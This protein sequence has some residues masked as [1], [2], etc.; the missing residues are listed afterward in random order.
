Y[1]TPLNSARK[2]TDLVAGSILKLEGR[3]GGFYEVAYPDGRTG[4]IASD[5]AQPLDEWARSTEASQASLVQTAKTMMGAPYLW[6]GTSTK[7]IDC[8]GFTKTI[9][10]MNGQV[11]PRDTS[12]QVNAGVLVDS[13]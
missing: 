6:G 13:Q 12:Q 9:Y 2:V 5:E 10:L 4:Y 11:I 1:Q 7:S 8:S 3:A